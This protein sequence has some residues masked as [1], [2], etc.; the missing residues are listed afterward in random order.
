L[1]LFAVLSGLLYHCP[2]QPARASEY[3]DALLVYPDA[4]DVRSGKREATEELEYHVDAK[5]PASNVIGWISHKLQGTGW[6]PLTHD[7]LNPNLPSSQAQGWQDFLAG[8]KAPGSCIH[9]WIGNWRDV[10]G[11]FVRYALRYTQTECGAPDLTDLRSVPKLTELEV[12]AAYVPAAVAR[13]MQEAVEQF[14]R[15]HGRGSEPE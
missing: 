7:F 10:S 2:I 3:P 15:E 14:K 12:T 11:N 6:K 5:F 4:K 1:V 9:Q 8:P 13:Q